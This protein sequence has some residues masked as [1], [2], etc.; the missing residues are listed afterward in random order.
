MNLRA[1]QVVVRVDVRDHPKSLACM[2]KNGQTALRQFIA[3]DFTPA[4]VGWAHAMAVERLFVA[5]YGWTRA[6]ANETGMVLTWLNR[7]AADNGVTV[8]GMTADHQTVVSA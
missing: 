4:D 5:L 6:H 1:V 7:L 2:S 3:P 8:H